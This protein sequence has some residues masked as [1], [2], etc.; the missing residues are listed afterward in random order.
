MSRVPS[1]RPLRLRTLALTAV[2]A[3]AFAGSALA[4]SQPYEQIRPAPQGWTVDLGVGAL[5]SKDSGGD[6]GSETQVVPWVSANYRDV[7]YVNAIDGL[8]WNA[9]KT[10]DFRAGLQLRPRFSPEDIEGLDLDRPDFGAD[11]AA[12]AFKRLP[13]NIVVGGRV[14]RDVSDV[15][16]GTEYYASVGHQRVTPIGLMNVSVYAR[17]GDAKLADAYYGVSAA[18]AARN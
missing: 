9:V 6:T 17:G 15:S 16:E 18:E 11:V 10:D 3:T 8:G 4:Q 1:P 2:A 12:Y 5:Y 7:V 14:S 13:G